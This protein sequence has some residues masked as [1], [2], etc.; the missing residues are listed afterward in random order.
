MKR[1]SAADVSIFTIT[2]GP[3]LDVVLHLKTD[4]IG[5]GTIRVVSVDQ[6]PGG[7]GIDVSRAVKAL[8]GKTVAIAALGPEIGKNVG[9]L[10][11]QEGLE[12]SAV[13]VSGD[14]RTNYIFK[15]PNGDEYR[16]NNSVPAMDA[17]EVA[18]FYNHI[19]DRVDDD[20]VVTIGGRAPSNFHNC[21]CERLIRVLRD[22]KRCKV[23]LDVS[24]EVTRA[25]LRN[26]YSR[27]D[28]IKPNLEEFHE[29]LLSSPGQHDGD[30]LLPPGC[31]S[32]ARLESMG[33]EAYLEWLFT[34][35][36]GNDAIGGSWTH[37][38]RAVAAFY[39]AHDRTVVPIISLGREGC[40]MA[41]EESASVVG[42]IHC[43]HPEPVRVVARVGAGDSLLGAYLLGCVRGSSLSKA[44]EFAVSAAT[45]RVSMQV[46][47][48][49]QEY[50]SRTVVEKKVN[51]H[52]ITT[53]FYE[54]PVADATMPRFLQR[55]F[56]QLSA[57]TIVRG[58]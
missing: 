49:M 45:V 46:Q 28:F 20:S 41:V 32:S 6:R 18:R 44:L 30:G 26:D 19:L 25:C 1:S 29:L 8:G 24:A 36:N 58:A 21:W 11:M 34:S 38:L 31:A 9:A 3:C 47:E 10:V 7:K 37:L 22:E 56:N 35:A 13:D 55:R 50:I 23:A 39:D 14:T 51:D 43:Y 15:T 48:E 27:P 33:R 53:D 52:E 5:P 54:V 16:F 12:I 42:I 57:T 2:P 4:K 40:L 17:R